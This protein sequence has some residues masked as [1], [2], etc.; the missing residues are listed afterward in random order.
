[1]KNSTIRKAT[2]IG[3]ALIAIT[4]LSMQSVALFEQNNPTPKNLGMPPNWYEKF[5]S[6]SDGQ[7]LDG[8]PDDGGWVGWDDDPNAGA[9]VTSERSITPPN[10]LIISGPTD[11]IHQFEGYNSGVWNFSAWV[12]VPSDYEGSG[13]FIMLNTYYHGGGQEGNSWSAQI[14]MDSFTE[15]VIADFDGWELPL[16]FDEWTQFLA[17]IDLDQDYYEMYYNDEILE[18]KEWTAGPSNDFT[19]VLN[20]ACLDLFANGATVVYYDDIA[21]RAWGSPPEPD[22]SAAGSINFVNVTTGST[23]AG[24]FTVVNAGSAGSTLNWEVESYPDWGDWTITPDSGTTDQGDI[25]NVDVSIVAPSD[26][27]SIFDGEVK[28][29]NSDNPDDFA[30]IQCYLSTPKPKM[31]FVYKFL[32]QF[33]VLQKLFGL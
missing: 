7:L 4:M 9:Y 28:I 15:M 29:V 20:I 32:E 17:V 16:V 30:I 8:S 6:Y 10:S 1:M 22:L 18:Y 12:Y 21:F 19:G 13:S 23:N 25:V 14:G 31:I 26:T 11:L 5:D 24:G 3:A 2:V 33:P 27:N